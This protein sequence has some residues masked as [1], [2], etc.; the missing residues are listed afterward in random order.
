L[1]AGRHSYFEWT[2]TPD[3]LQGAL[4]DHDYEQYHKPLGQPLGPAERNGYV[5]TRRYDHLDVRV[6]IQSKEAVLRWH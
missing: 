3:A 4:Q 1:V 5:Y 6:N 2:C